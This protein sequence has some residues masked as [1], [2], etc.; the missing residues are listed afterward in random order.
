MQL[1]YLV[2]HHIVLLIIGKK[3]KKKKLFFDMKMLLSLHFCLIFLILRQLFVC[4][5]VGLALPRQGYCF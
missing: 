5:F 1:H 2:R 4:L 3:K